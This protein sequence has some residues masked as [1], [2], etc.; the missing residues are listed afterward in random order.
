MMNAV[1]QAALSLSAFPLS[2]LL[3][4]TVIL[5]VAFLIL[6]GMRPA[7]A[8]ARHLVLTAAFGVLTVLPAAER[9]V[10]SIGIPIDGIQTAPL[11]P[12]TRVDTAADVAGA[13]PPARPGSRGPSA[14]GG[15]PWSRQRLLFAAWGLGAFVCLV[16]V[17]LTP[18]RLRHLRRSARRWSRA[19]ELLRTIDPTARP[20]AVFLHDEETAPLACGIVRPVILLPAA[21][22]RWSED[23]IARALIH[24]LEHVRRADWPVC[25]AT[26]IISAVYWF[27]PLVWIAWRR[28]GLEAE[29]AADDAVLCES[30]RTAYAQQLV[31]LAK[32]RWR[33]SAIP[34]LSMAGRSDLSARV[35]AVLDETQTRGR[36]GRARAAVILAAAGLLVMAVAPLR[37]QATPIAPVEKGD[38]PAFDVVSI[39]ENISGEFFGSFGYDPGGQLTVVNNAV[40]NLI[41]NAYSVQNHQI[42]GGPEWM[43]SARYDI[44]AKSSGNPSQDR[45]RLMVRRLLVERFKLVAHR[46]TRDIP[47][48]ALV[49]ARPG[50]LGPE[51][52]PAKVDCMA[53]AA[54]AEKQ[55]TKPEFPQPPD[56]RPACGTRSAPGLM[57]G[58][59]VS[60]ADL[61][62]NL[63]GPADRMVIDRTALAGVWDLDLKYVPDQP[64]PDIP[65]LPAPP[66][67]GASLFT[68]LQEQL[69]LRLESQMA[70]VDLLVIDSIERPS[71]N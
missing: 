26:R 61:V 3:K 14:Q 54:A 49:V 2:V 18:W 69:G 8:S 31:T 17:L 52:R 55:G 34:V 70:P 56:N 38:A 32:E 59:G 16:P 35:A 48:Y 67:D 22:A 57:M 46:E 20:V 58:T 36:L 13:A 41:R 40:R 50:R 10:P 24:E 9:V 47:I 4:A 64:L 43:N 19:E 7:A 5:G 37:A 6:R 12:I 66:A 44:T 33:A 42:V 21:A 30:E 39:R 15:S 23:D 45:L 53:I 62:R 60:M 63:A 11:L 65:G 25:I 29:R 68:A 51:L 1:A 28:L 27:H 71:E